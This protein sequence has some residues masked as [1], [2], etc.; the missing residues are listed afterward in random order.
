MEPNELFRQVREQLP[1]VVTPDACM[2]RQELADL[3]NRWLFDEK[4][5]HYT[6]DANYIGK[7]E[8]GVIR[9]PHADYRD[10]F[11]ATLRVA[12]DRELGLYPQRRRA[13]TVADVNRQEFLRAAVAS[14]G[15]LAAMP[16]LDLFA[17]TT[18]TAV[19]TRVGRTEIDHVR[20][21]TETFVRWDYS[22]GGGLARETVAAQLRQSAQLLHADC[23]SKLR[24]ELFAAVSGLGEVAGFMAFD[25]YAH[26][27]ARR[28]FRFAL[29]CAEEADDWH[30]RAHLLASMARQEVWCDN[31]DGG[32]TYVEMALVRADRLTATERAMLS[33]VRARAL[34]KLE[35]TQECLAAVGSADEAFA[36]ADSAEDPPWMAFYDIPQHHGDTGHALFDLAVKSSA[37]TEA[38]P[39]LAYSVA[40]HGPAYARSQ[41]ISQIKLASLHMATGDPHEAAAIGQRALSAAGYLRSRR[42]TDYL[43]E[44]AR[45]SGRHQDVPA[46][47]ELRDRI[48][49]VVNAA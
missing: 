5:K 30:I 29:A 41:A 49:N 13:D 22:F 25:T 24:G 33:T 27:D 3:V 38:A 19:P 39:R 46:A 26:D 12:T 15:A 42:A 21:A 47:A 14:A 6:L 31:P 2:S 44:L 34:A 17:P 16:V 20:I 18:P 36:H 28:M 37:N 11:R 40:H 35:R 1:S 48:R 9:W 43:R 7:L 23:P 45:Y 4:D 32:L 10:A 8:R